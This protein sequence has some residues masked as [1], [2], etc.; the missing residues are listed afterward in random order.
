MNGMSFYVLNDRF[1]CSEGKTPI[2]VDLAGD[3][4]DRSA[5]TGFNEG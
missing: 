3:Q 4:T 2:N 5:S 1:Y